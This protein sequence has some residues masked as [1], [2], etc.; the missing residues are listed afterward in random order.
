M[1]DTWFPPTGCTPYPQF[2]PLRQDMALPLFTCFLSV[3]YLFYIGFRI[4]WWLRFRLSIAARQYAPCHHVPQMAA[5]LC[6]YSC[7]ECTIFLL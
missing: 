2:I 1:P 4:G 7:G 3:V 5:V 6:S